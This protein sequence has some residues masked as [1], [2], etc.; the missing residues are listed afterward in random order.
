[1]K[2]EIA[3]VEVLEHMTKIYKELNVKGYRVEDAKKKALL[4]EIYLI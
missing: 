3:K 4:K 2:D 1:M